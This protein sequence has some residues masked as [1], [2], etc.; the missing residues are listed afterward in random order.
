MPAKPRRLPVRLE[1]A[2]VRLAV[3][4]RRD[5]VR[6]E[7]ERLELER[8]REDPARDVDRDRVEPDLVDRERADELLRLVLL[9]LEP[10][11]RA[12]ERPELFLP[13]CAFV[14]PFS[15][16]ILFT[17]RAATSSARPP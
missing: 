6:E 3:P 8:P 10:E 15:R 5:D 12:L 9:D 13:R 16:R 7:L 1:P 11:R 2:E 4:L 14:S 17:V